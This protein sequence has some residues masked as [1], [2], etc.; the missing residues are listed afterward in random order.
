MPNSGV[1]TM[2]TRKPSA[3]LSVA[4]AT[5]DRN[6]GAEREHRRMRYVQDAQKPVDKREPHCHHGI[7]APE[8]QTGHSQVDVVHRLILNKSG[9]GHRGSAAHPTLFL[10]RRESV[11]DPRAWRRI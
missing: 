10:R 7:H 1:N 11:R 2:A 9:E 8:A 5:N 6:I 3:M 4:L